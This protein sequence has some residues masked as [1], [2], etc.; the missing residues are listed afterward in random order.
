MNSFLPL[1]KK[2]FF[3]FTCAGQSVCIRLSAGRGAGREQQASAAAGVRPGPGAES[4]SDM[5]IAVGAGF[6]DGSVYSV[7]KGGSVWVCK[8]SS[9]DRPESRGFVEDTSVPFRRKINDLEL[10][11]QIY[12]TL[13]F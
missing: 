10:A 3:F 11:C 8:D 13:N 2:P 12:R 6:G 7:G 4:G 9:V 1:E 5:G